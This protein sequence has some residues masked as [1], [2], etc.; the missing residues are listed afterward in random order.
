MTFI[1]PPPHSSPASQGEQM[2]ALTTNVDRWGARSRY[3]GMDDEGDN[4]TRPGR[5]T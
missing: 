4:N 3:W 1:S 5:P 2:Q